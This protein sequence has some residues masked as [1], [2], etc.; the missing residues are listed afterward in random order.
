MHV[1]C[2]L[3]GVVQKEVQQ[4]DTWGGVC[5]TRRRNAKN[6]VEEGGV[7]VCVC[8]T[9]RR[10]ATNQPPVVLRLTL[11]DAKALSSA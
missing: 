9:R 1:G 7:K 4:G 8:I 10:N 5:K 11:A 2:G 3:V 6:D